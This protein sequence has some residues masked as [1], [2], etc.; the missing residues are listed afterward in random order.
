MQHPLSQTEW[1][2]L[3]MI[4]IFLFAGAVLIAIALFAGIRASRM[5]RATSVV[6]QVPKANTRAVGPEN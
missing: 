3:A 4:L 5:R 6:T 1:K 2:E